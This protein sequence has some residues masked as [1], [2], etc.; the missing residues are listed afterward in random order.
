MFFER[1]ADNCLMEA[2]NTLDEIVVLSL[3]SLRRAPTGLAALLSAGAEALD[4]DLV[5]AYLAPAASL[6]EALFGGGID[7]PVLSQRAGEDHRMLAYLTSQMAPA[8]VPADAREGQW[9]EYEHVAAIASCLD[10]HTNCVVI[11]GGQKP[12]GH[13]TL[14]RISAPVALLTYVIVQD[15]RSREL[16]RDAIEADQDLSLL[17]AGLHHDLKTPLTGILG[18]AKTIINKDEVLTD[19]V[20]GEMLDSI[21]RQADR[22]TRMVGDALNRDRDREGPVRAEAVNLRHLAERA[23]SAAMMGRSGIVVVEA[24]DVEF[25]TDGDRVERVLLNLLDNALKYAPDGTNVFLVAEENEGWAKFTV[26]DNGPG[27]AQDVLPRLFA[28]YVSDPTRS[29]G[30]GLGLNSAKQVIEQELGGRL[31]YSRREGWTRFSVTVPGEA[32]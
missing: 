19:E 32:T 28:P 1:R 14:R 15:R 17:L 20:R 22:L 25:H 3:R 29:E 11:A 5:A 9:C 21:V 6:P 26:A 10:E 2:D 30:T 31:A 12:I 8:D 16:R 23:S 4:A 24:P 7:G 27:V 18:S 13:E